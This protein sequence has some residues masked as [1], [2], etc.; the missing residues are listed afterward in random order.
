MGRMGVAAIVSGLLA[1][2]LLFG[3]SART[4]GQ[5][6][7]PIVSQVRPEPVEL[8]NSQTKGSFAVSPDTLVS[9]PPVLAL[10]FTRVVNPANTPFVVFVYLSYRPAE[11]EGTA[12]R[13]ILL[14]NGSLY[15]A[16]RPG[17]FRL[18]A[19]AA[20]AKLKAAKATDVRLMLEM[21]RLRPAEPWSQVEVTVAPPQWLSEGGNTD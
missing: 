13:R 5:R 7:D 20:F 6:V 11:T 12:S 19:S 8:T 9:A 21:K 2:A 15:P 1:G 3:G 14:G 16:D 17:G 10:S 18:R 4:E